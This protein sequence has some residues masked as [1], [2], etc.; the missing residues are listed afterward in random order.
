MNLALAHD[1]GPYP[2][3]SPVMPANILGI[4]P[5]AQGFV[6]ET[7]GFVTN[8]PDFGL[9]CPKKALKWPILA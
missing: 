6:T 3:A 2:T 4:C 5:Y 9:F 7:S 8:L 1:L